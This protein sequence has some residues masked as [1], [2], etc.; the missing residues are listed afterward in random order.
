MKRQRWSDKEVPQWKFCALAA[1]K[2]RSEEEDEDEKDNEGWSSSIILHP[3]YYRFASGF[4]LG[5]TK[6]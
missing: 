2:L 3:L 5:T 6:Q 1:L 4:H